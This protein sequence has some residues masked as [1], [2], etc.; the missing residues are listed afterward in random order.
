M[1]SV[2]H[3]SEPSICSIPLG[4]S[5]SCSD[6]DDF[7]CM[8][9]RVEGSMDTPNGCVTEDNINQCNTQSTIGSVT[10]YHCCCYSDYC[11]KDL[12]TCRSGSIMQH[13][14]FLIMVT[15]TLVSLLM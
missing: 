9:T 15:A 7:H 14:S 4:D 6:R 1:G 3:Y 8:V 13:G 12:K 10:T 5:E 2:L 11:N